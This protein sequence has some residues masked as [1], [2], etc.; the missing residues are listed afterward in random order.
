MWN[1][2][3]P[4]MFS[5]RVGHLA[6]VETLIGDYKVNYECGDN[7][8]MT[9]LHIAC[10]YVPPWCWYMLRTEC[11]LGRFIKWLP[12]CNQLHAAYALQQRHDLLAGY[13]SCTVSCKSQIPELSTESMCT[14]FE[15]GITN[16][17]IVIQ[18]PVRTASWDFE[19]RW[20]HALLSVKCC[21]FVW[22]PHM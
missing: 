1:H 5:C 10:R 2:L 14:H 15:N 13:Y 17:A 7:E 3:L 8:G 4:I 9:P 19:K 16:E 20:T 22:K 12:V 6:I 11:N 18:R 21:Y